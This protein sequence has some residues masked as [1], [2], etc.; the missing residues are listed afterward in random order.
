VLSIEA[1]TPPQDSGLFTQD[2]MNFS[3]SEKLERLHVVTDS[4][5]DAI[6]RFKPQAAPGG[7]YI[8][9]TKALLRA[10]ELARTGTNLDL[11]VGK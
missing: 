4:L 11:M 5:F 7:R 3:P 8:E 9:E 10:P 6:C 1:C 2:F